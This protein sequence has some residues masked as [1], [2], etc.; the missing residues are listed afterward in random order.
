M[1]GVKRVSSVNSSSRSERVSFTVQAKRRVCSRIEF[2]GRWRRP[3]GAEFYSW[4]CLISF[5]LLLFPISIA[6]TKS[7]CICT[8]STETGPLD[9]I[10]IQI[11]NQEAEFLGDKRSF[12]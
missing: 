1:P 10:E 8:T 3:R 7:Y 5:P 2:L 12:T 11:T 4:F 6:G 9:A